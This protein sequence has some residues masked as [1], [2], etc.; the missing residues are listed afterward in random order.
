MIYNLLTFATTLLDSSSDTR[1]QNLEAGIIVLGVLFFIVLA[2]LIS[3]FII[4][5]RQNDKL[6]KLLEQYKD[7]KPTDNENK[8][9]K[10]DGN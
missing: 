7:K 6:T 1:I 3:F 2:A 9:S 4:L 8:N 10:D 5:E